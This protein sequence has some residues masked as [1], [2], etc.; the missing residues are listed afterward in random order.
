MTTYEI[1]DETL[2]LIPK[3]DNTTWI[4]EKGQKL[5]VDQSVDSIMEN[6][7]E[8]FGSSLQG[9]QNGTTA[10][11]GIT[12]KVPIIV[13]ESSNLIFF[14]TS[15]PRLKSCCWIS[16]NNIVSYSKDNN[17]CKVVF[18]DGKILKFDTSFGIINN[19]ILRA[20]RLQMMLDARKRNKVPKTAKK[21][22]NIG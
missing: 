2:A 8:Y 13:E 6:S 12:H 22:R 21:V 20:S 10:L 4:Y 15:S 1:N 14:P 3:N 17:I 5:F 19:Q 18:K 9:R 7:C 16:L 11:I